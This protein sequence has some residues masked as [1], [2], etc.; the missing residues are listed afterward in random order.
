ML[1]IYWGIVIIAIG[2]LSD[3]SVFLGDF[4]PLNFI[5][6]GFGIFWLGKGILGLNKKKREHT[7]SDEPS[8]NSA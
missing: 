5:F 6:D 8:G 1:D 3:Q 2:V 7:Q 4:S